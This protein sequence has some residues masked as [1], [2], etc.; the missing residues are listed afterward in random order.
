VLSS[1]TVLELTAPVKLTL[2]QI[3][4]SKVEIGSDI[5]SIALTPPYIPEYILQRLL[6]IL[7]KSVKDTMPDVS[8]AS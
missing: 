2:W 3:N 7:R 8:K 1:V 5:V 4:L 6:A